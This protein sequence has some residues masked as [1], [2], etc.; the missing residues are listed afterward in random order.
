MRTILTSWQSA[1]VA[2]ALIPTLNASGSIVTEC[3]GLKPSNQSIRDREVVSKTFDEIVENFVAQSTLLP[4]ISI[5]VVKDDAVVYGQSFGYRDLE[6]CTPVTADTRFYLK[7][8]TKSFVGM[9]AAVLHETGTIDLD[10]PISDYLPQLVLPKEINA[11]QIS[12]RDHFTHTQPYLDSGLTFRIAFPGNLSSNDFI[13]HVNRFARVTDIKFQYSNFGPVIG[14]HAIRENTGIDWHDLIS[15]Y[16]FTPA[17]MSD[18]FT[19]IAEAENGPLAKSYIRNE[20]GVFVKTQTKADG[21]MHAAGG[22]ISTTED[23]SRWLVLN[24]NGG[25]LK[26][27]QLL[28]KR[29]VEHAQSRQVYLDWDFLGFHR[30][31]HGLGVYSADY[32]GNL[33]MHHFGGET[34]VSFMPEQGIGVV[35]LTNA[36]GEGV[37]VTHRLA[38]TIYD[39]LLNEPDVKG[40]ILKRL[41][42]IRTRVSSLKQRNL[43]Y[44]KSMRDAAPKGQAVFG[45]NDLN[46]RYND[47]RL[48]SIEVSIS[49]K[50]LVFRFGEMSG[51]LTHL[52]GDSFLADFGMWDEFPELF[53][54]RYDKASGIVLDWDGRIFIRM[55]D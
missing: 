44:R 19:S 22:A 27:A 41:E 47:E 46:G 18:S 14:A 39:I 45:L 51:R 42:I 20:D 2:F 15:D 12:L 1:I 13:S 10:A 24:L 3:V 9:A 37:H 26:G 38:A 34:H 29:V 50:G 23:L 33:L 7:S 28:P 30:F 5:S 54:F 43:E 4:G 21:Q 35:V 31:A 52:V 8:T 32:D 25:T 49:S 48:G 16:V 36:I 6:F 11:A 55:G 40:N 53:V 17:G